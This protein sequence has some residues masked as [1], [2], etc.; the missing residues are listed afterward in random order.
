MRHLQQYSLK[1]SILTSE[2]FTLRFQGLPSFLGGFKFEDM[3]SRK[4]HTAIIGQCSL[5]LERSNR[6]DERDL[7]LHLVVRMA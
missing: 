7:D 6:N 4:E 3:T 5:Q 1:G 2:P